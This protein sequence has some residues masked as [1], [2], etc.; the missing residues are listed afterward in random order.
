MDNNTTKRDK[1]KKDVYGFMSCKLK[2]KL[3]WKRKCRFLF[4]CHVEPNASFEAAYLVR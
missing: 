3:E 1:K 4:A 2:V